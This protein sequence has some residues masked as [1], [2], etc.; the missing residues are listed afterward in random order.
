[1]T[2][3]YKEQSAMVARILD[4]LEPLGIEPT[5]INL[6]KH[7]SEAAERVLFYNCMIWLLQEEII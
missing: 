3:K 4:I 7:T 2:D 1:M 6:D 5:T